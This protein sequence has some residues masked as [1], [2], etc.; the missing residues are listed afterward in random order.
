MCAEKRGRPWLEKRRHIFYEEPQKP[1]ERTAKP[2]VP[3]TEGHYCLVLQDQD[4]F[5]YLS[6]GKKRDAQL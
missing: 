4:Y 3:V 6:F 1:R 2:C 5:A